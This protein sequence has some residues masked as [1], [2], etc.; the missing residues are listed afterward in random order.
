MH[1]WIIGLTTPLPKDNS[2]FSG[3]L[4]RVLFNSAPLRWLGK[5]SYALYCT[6]FV[7]FY[8]CGNSG[9][10]LSFRCALPPNPAPPAN[11]HA[12]RCA[13]SVAGGVSN[14]AVPVLLRF[15]NGTIVAAVTPA[16]PGATYG[17]WYFPGLAIIPC[18]AVCLL[19]AILVWL[20]LER[21][22]RAAIAQGA[23]V[24]GLLS[25]LL[26]DQDATGS[27]KAPAAITVQ[28]G[29]SSSAAS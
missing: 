6:H 23:S 4:S 17:W 10:S 15:D 24:S 19:V 27:S 28:A 22:A 7:V 3:G 18:V 20:V 29:G 21:P 25:A 12:C 16:P 14:T 13:Y 2:V 8:W 9:G 1:W 5:V 26:Q 11:K